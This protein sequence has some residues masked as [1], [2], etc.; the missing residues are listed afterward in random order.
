LEDLEKATREDSEDSKAGVGQDEREG[1][2]TAGYCKALGHPGTRWRDS[3]D[4]LLHA[5]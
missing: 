2:P 1:E 5:M 4:G 3:V